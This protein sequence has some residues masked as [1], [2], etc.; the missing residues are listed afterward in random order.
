VD[1]ID[2]AWSYPYAE[3]GFNP[4]VAHGVIYT[5]ARNQSIVAIDAAT[6]KEIWI[7]DG[8]TGMTIRGMNFWESKDGSDRRLIFWV[9]D[10]MQE[11]DASTGKSV[12]TFGKNGAVDL[13][14][15]LMRDPNFIRAQSGTPG[16]VWEDLIIIGSA[17][18]E[19]YFSAPGDVRAYNAVTGKL[20]WQFHTIPH[21]GEFGYETWPKD[22]WKYIGGVNTWG[23]LSIDS[24]RGIAY[25]PLGSPTFDFYGADRVGDGL[26]GTSLLALDA[27][28][29]KRLWHFQN[30]HHDLWDYDNVAAPQ[31]TTITKG[32]KKIDVVAMAG[33]TGYLYVFNRVTGE[34]IWPMPETPVP[35][36]S[37][38]PGEV[39]SPTQPIPSAPPPFTPHSFTVDDIN[40]Y[41]LTDKERTDL[42]ARVKAARYQGPFTPIGFDDVIH[43]PGNQGGT[44]WGMTSANPN[45]GTVYVMAYNF[46]TLMKLLPAGQ[47]RGGRGGAGAGIY[48]RNCA[49]CHGTDRAGLSG[50]PSLVGVSTRLKEDELRLRIVDGRGQMPSFHQLPATEI[51]A[52]VTYLTA[53]DAF[54]G[55]G[56]RGGRGAAPIL[57]FPAGPV[58][59]TGPVM[60]RPPAP[61][62]AHPMDEYPEAVPHPDDRLTMDGYGVEVY[63]RK[64]P[65]TTLTAYDLN[66]GTIK[67]QIGAGD[68]YRV[69][70][71]GGPHGTGAATT[72][73]S[74][75]L[76]T[77]TG[78]VIVNTADRRIHI[79]DAETGKELRAIALGSLTSGSSSMYE[80]NGK[81]YLL[82]SASAVGTR[83]GSDDKAADPNQKGPVGLLAFA[84]RQ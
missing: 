51:D 15:E 47:G 41:I 73:K 63:A 82:V 68:D 21:P 39:V 10:Y 83:Q 4:I 75:S 13:R 74:S 35:H 70:Q 30:V 55:R 84:I 69:V 11:L 33:K 26:Y 80:L 24:V 16:K 18:G 27:R 28:T 77:S 79:Y 66:K 76:I 54:G 46:P 59:Q 7:H 53:S 71:A 8:L 25:F 43:M 62:G 5:R 12:T 36:E 61:G 44:N 20:A 65:Y 38:V 29:G 45:D 56:G 37:N 50:M 17:V 2:V 14:D 32:G 3:T 58:V 81:Q 23:E 19:G 22:A 64:P 40:P 78:L 49:G 52:L 72:L 34:P 57:D 48:T 42:T 31:L 1:Q 60:K 6:G 9:A 67:W